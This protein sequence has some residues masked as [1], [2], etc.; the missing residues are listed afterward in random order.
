MSLS[1]EQ[2]SLIRQSFDVLL[3]NLEPNSTNFYEE[4][5]RQAPEL[6]GMFRDDL[7]GQGMK[8]MSTLRVMVDNLNKPDALAA[9]YADLGAQH[10]RLGVTAEM[11]V[12]MC[13]ALIITFR[14][15]LGDQF[16][17]ETE[18][19]WRTAYFDLTRAL[20]ETGGIPRG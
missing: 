11:F 8:F 16:P 9:R 17:D 4:L 10:R 19:A 18:A 2:L 14:E 1:D 5:F 15:V 12:P 13:E 20:I 6:R 7:G 3:E